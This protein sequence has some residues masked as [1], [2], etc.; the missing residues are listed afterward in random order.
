MRMDR[1]GSVTFGLLEGV[2]QGVAVDWAVDP[3]G[4]LMV[5]MQKVETVPSRE[6]QI[7]V[8]DTERISWERSRGG[9]WS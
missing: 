5:G 9:R 1:V 2:E 4:A 3:S 6:E 7:Q 8:R